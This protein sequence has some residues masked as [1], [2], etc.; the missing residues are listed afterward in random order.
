M[1]KILPFLIALLIPLTAASGAGTP[2]EQKAE[3]TDQQFSE[4]VTLLFHK[5]RQKQATHFSRLGKSFLDDPKR[6]EFGTYWSD[7]PGFNY[8]IIDRKKMKYEFN[9]M[10]GNWGMKIHGDIHQQGWELQCKEPKVIRFMHINR[11]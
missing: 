1:I 7:N 3:F 6:I 11:R 2:N 5:E 4:A 10:I 8:F 9:Y